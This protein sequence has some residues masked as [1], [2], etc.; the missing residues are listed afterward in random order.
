MRTLGGVIIPLVTPFTEDGRVDVDMLARNLNKWNGTKVGG[1]MCLGTNGEF[2]SLSDEESIHVISAFVQA[3]AREKTRIVGIGRESLAHTLS[4]MEQLSAFESEIDYYSVITPSYFSSQMTEDALYTYYSQ[5][6]NVSRIPV[7]LYTA[8][9]YANR[10][11]ISPHLLRR[12]ANHPNIMGIK[13]TSPD[14]MD[15]YMEVVG[16]R[17]DFEVMAGSI[18]NLLRCLEKGGKGGVLSA[19][20]YLP[21]ECAQI[22]TLFENGENMAAI[23]LQDWIR[24]LISKTASPFGVS[25]VKACMS[26]LGYEGGYP[27]LPLLPLSIAAKKAIEVEFIASNALKKS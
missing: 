7:L 24:T 8:P 20:N 25:G 9:T 14:M 3:A 10:V 21:N 23:A 19:A 2:K 13:D 4:F 5:I 1:Y 11:V 17:D 22:V 26:L 18:N 12:L 27:R 15:R 6:A 16:K